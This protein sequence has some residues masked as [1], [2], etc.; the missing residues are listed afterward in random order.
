MTALE[1]TLE[2]YDAFADR[3]NCLPDEAL[4][5]ASLPDDDACEY[6]YEDEGGES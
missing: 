6:G 4:L 1:Q 2:P 5:E 3:L